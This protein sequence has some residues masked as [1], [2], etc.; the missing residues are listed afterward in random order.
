M[1]AD[2]MCPQAGADNGMDAEKACAVAACAC[3]D[4][5]ADSGT[6]SPMLEHVVVLDNY[7]EAPGVW[8]VVLDSPRVA[9]QVAP[10]QFVHVRLTGFEAHILRRPISV[11]DADL[12]QG[13]I[14][15]MYQVVGAGTDWMTRLEEGDELDVLGP[16]GHGW[17]PPVG[18]SRALLVTGGLGAAP[19]SLLAEQLMDR[20]VAVETIM[21]APSS[22]R[23]VCRDRLEVEGLGTVEIATDDGSEGL[24]G[25][26]TVL[27]EQR[28][29]RAVSGEAE[30]PGYIAVCGPA[31]MMKIVCGAVERL[32]PGVPC[33]VSLEKR[34]A[35][36]IGACLSCAVDTID[37]SRRSCKDGPVFDAR[38]V[39]W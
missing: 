2:G 33:D 6:L 5:A 27:A 19:L 9:A 28:L 3:T 8:V 23:L 21:G 20:G 34:M 15:L 10:G 13:S 7:E 1:R 18:I 30:M 32:A 11:Y 4:A 12:G 17:N 36:G 25:F 38:K 22:D 39:V 14:A 24:H 37:G 26:C 35:C 16:L 31:P 29:D